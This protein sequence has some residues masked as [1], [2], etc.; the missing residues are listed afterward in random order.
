MRSLMRKVATA[1]AAAALLLVGG[2]AS[3]GEFP[4]VRQEADV[5]LMA[6]GADVGK[7]TLVRGPNGVTMFIRSAVEGELVQGYEP[8]GVE[9]APGDATIVTFVVFNEPANCTGGVCDGD[10]IADA[11]FLG[12]PNAPMLGLH[13]A[14]GHVA[15]GEVW[16]AGGRLRE[17]DM[18]SIAELFPGEPLP[19]YPLIDAM[20]AEIHVVIASHGPAANLSRQERFDALRTLVGGCE[21]NVCGDVQL[22]VFPAP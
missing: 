10:D 4:I 20:D 6:G 8:I 15:R 2:A 3:A 13:H 5:R 14:A 21:T 18:R 19:G 9:W 1:A 7:A 22:A 11:L 16:H 17:G 12:G